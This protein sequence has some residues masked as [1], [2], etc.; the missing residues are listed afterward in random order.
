ME[1]H[2]I[3]GLEELHRR[4]V[5]DIEWFWSAVLEELGV[6]FYRPYDGLL[7]LSN[8][9][10]WPRWCCGAQMNIVHNCLDKWMATPVARRDAVRWEGEDRSEEH[11]SELQS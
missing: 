4:S 9:I 10:A 3:G 5:Y 11:T 7:D 2:G 8:G 1:R 6:E